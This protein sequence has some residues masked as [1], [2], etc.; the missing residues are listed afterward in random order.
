[1]LNSIS[2]FAACALSGFMNAYFMRQTEIKKGID[3]CD[4]NTGKSYGKSKICANTAVLQTSISRI[5]LVLTIFVPPIFLIAMERARIMPKNR[6]GKFSIE[7][8]VL[9]LELYFAV[10]LGLAFYPRQGTVAAKDIEPEF[11][12]VKDDQGNLITE[13]VFNKGL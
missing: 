2:S 8:S 9:C 3:V 12:E 1:M 7:L 5:A 11:S 6:V 13:F 4:K 10:P